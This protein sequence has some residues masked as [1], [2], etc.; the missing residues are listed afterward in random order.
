[1]AKEHLL[2]VEDEEDILEL[3]LMDEPGWAIDPIS[4]T[5]PICTNPAHKPTARSI[6]GWFG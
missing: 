3:L 5:Q 1:M 4:V 6:T 2:V